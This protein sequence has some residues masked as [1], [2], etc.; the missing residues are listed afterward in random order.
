MIRSDLFQVE[1]LFERHIDK[2]IDFIS[3][4]VFEVGETNR[5]IGHS[6]RKDCSVSANQF[7]TDKLHPLVFDPKFKIGAGAMK[8]TFPIFNFMY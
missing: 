3:D 2:F 7:G 8:L 4:P 1:I 6:V 5:V